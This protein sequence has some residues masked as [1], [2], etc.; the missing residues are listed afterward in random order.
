MSFK[1]F[2]VFAI[3]VV[4]CQLPAA[5][6]ASP[7][8]GVVQADGSFFVDEAQ[9]V[10]T[11]TLFE[12]TV[13][14][15]AS[16]SPQLHVDQGI[17]FALAAHS[18]SKVFG[19]RIVLEQGAG[20]IER[21]EESFRVAPAQRDSVARISLHENNAVQV[22][23]LRGEFRVTNADGVLLAAVPAGRALEFSPQAAGAAAAAAV[24]GCLQQANGAYYIVDET[25]GVTMEVRGEGLAGEAGNRVTVTGAPVPSANPRPGMSGVVQAGRIGRLSEG[26]GTRPAAAAPGRP[27]MSG[28]SGGAPAAGMSGATKAV[29]AGV[30]VA[31]AG[32]G[33]AIGL[34]R[35]DD[36]PKTISK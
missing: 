1:L 35:G 12:G 32:T 30:A 7:A 25:T 36:E 33:V 20:Q 9:V 3:A 34:T 5:F 15:A 21:M 4:A 2:S 22:A 19:D 27:G 8:I 26:C 17:Q 18:R 13:V 11:G 28:T 31:A 16:A 24:T 14:E 6:A 10:G 23:A 29:I